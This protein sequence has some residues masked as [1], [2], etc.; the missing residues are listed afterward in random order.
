[1][2]VRLTG[3]QPT[4]KQHAQ[5]LLIDWLDEYMV[6]TRDR[7]N[8]KAK[9]RSGLHR[10]YTKY[11]ARLRDKLAIAEDRIRDLK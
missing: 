10:E 8:R 9:I 1:M 4:G 7:E 3:T 2:T 6:G 11:G 5:D